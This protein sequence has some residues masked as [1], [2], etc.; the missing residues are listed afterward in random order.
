MVASSASTVL[1][2]INSLAPDRRAAVEA[3]RAVILENLPAGY[4][5]G[6][7][8]GMIGYCIPLSR[9]PKTY[10][11]QALMYLALASQKNYLSLYLTGI[12]AD[13]EKRSW[14]EDAYKKS[15]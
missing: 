7:E 9:Y 3:I 2:Y 10:N 4:Q 15:G 8:Y 12:Y 5:E 11:G 14:F 1:E 13:S 6:V